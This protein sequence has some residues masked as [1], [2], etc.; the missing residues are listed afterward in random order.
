LVIGAAATLAAFAFDN[1]ASDLPSVAAVPAFFDPASRAY[2][3]TRFFDRTGQ[4]VLAETAAGEPISLQ[5]AVTDP[6]LDLLIRATVAYLDPGFWGEPSDGRLASLSQRMSF[7]PFTSDPSRLSIAEQVI[8]Q[9][10]LPPGENRRAALARGL[11]LA[12][13][14]ADLQRAYTREQILEWYLNSAYFGHGAYGPEAASRVYFGRSLADLDLAQ[15][16]L[17][18]AIPAAPD[19]NPIDAPQ[20]AKA[21]QVDVLEA[22]ASQ[23]AADQAQIA[24]ALGAP[25]RLAPDLP[26]SAGPE[27]EFVARA[28]QQLADLL[29]PEFA[30]RGGLRVMT[31]LDLDIQL[32]AGCVV[33]TQ[34][35]RLSGEPPGTIIPAADGSPCVAASLLAPLRPGDAGIDRGLD[36]L[37]VVVLDPATGEVLSLTGLSRSGRAWQDLGL[38][39]AS[40]A[41]RRAGPTLY[42]FIY[43]TAFATGYG[44]G[45]MV[46]D[47]P[48][49]FAGTGGEGAYAPQD[50][51]GQTQGPI[52]LRTALANTLILPGARMLALLGPETV[53]RTTRQMGLESLEPPPAAGVGWVMEE[54][55]ATLLELAEAYGV[56]AAQGTLSGVARGAAEAGIDPVLVRQVQDAQGNVIYA[57]ERD[58]R[59]VLSP[60]LAYLLADVLSDEPARWET[61]GHPNVLEIGRPAGVIS[62]MGA[63]GADAWAV[64]FT[65]SRVVGVW[66]GTLDEEPA[67]GVS[68]VSSAGAV[69]SAIERYATRETPPVGWEMPPGLSVVEVCDPSGLLPTAYCP[70][71]VREIFVQ[72]SEPTNYDTLYQPFRI[73]RETGKLA[74]LFTPI[75]LVEE[76]VYLIPPPE[77]AA[78]AEAVGIDQPPQEYD[79]ITAQPGDP[80]VTLR[81]PMAF[82]VVR[83]VVP[84]QGS[85]DP[86]GFVSY[87]LQYGQG[88]NPTRWVQIG[89]DEEDPVEEGQLG[90][91]DT[92]GL[93]GLYT[94]QLLVV[95]EG[96]RVATAA[97]PVTIDNTSPIVTVLTPEAGAEL[98]VR[99]GGVVVV[100]LAAA[101]NLGI[102][103]VEI[104][105]DQRN[106]AT[107]SGEPYSIRWTPAT[108]GDHTLFARAYDL[109]GNRAESVPVM[110]VV[111][112]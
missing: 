18:A 60:Q 15:V 83:G 39:L 16:A 24:E 86:E 55:R 109:A 4:T 73:N 91:W 99:A 68:A 51:E 12:Y 80:H 67:N 63:S 43:L 112:R 56:V 104:Y 37:A 62:G 53:L 49:T 41:P 84:V 79:T 48:T 21:R 20:Q 78:W 3:P 50:A 6:G 17:L 33:A 96:D 76:R 92:A 82:D 98:E 90:E 5:T 72:G 47:I 1:L 11:R 44:P 30:Y 31:S 102:D 7:W 45:S 69:W 89:T 46:L 59:A 57:W 58:Q 26:E 110:V 100:E 19:L 77:A 28:R 111:R 13:L 95:R 101:D 14:A 94:L 107:L 29:G 64:G 27:A 87:R 61:L 103:H 36:G 85:A 65:P 35:A 38:G 54:G 25:L 70:N 52:R 74:T 108:A 105:V 2:R 88:L 23:E 75:D 81:T 97:V 40:Q 34:A 22:M 66:M 10:I 42:P 9:T 93:S 71:V 106:V 8:R 32:Q